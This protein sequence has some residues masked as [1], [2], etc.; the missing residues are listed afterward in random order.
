MTTS[1]LTYLGFVCLLLLQLT[2]AA[3]AEDLPR[4]EPGVLYLPDKA[5]A[6]GKIKLATMRYAKKK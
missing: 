2:S 4:Y 3:P 1:S 5:I 6:L